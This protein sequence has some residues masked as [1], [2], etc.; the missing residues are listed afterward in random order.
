M[1][2]FLAWHYAR[3][4]K[5]AAIGVG[6]G[7]SPGGKQFWRYLS[8]PFQSQMITRCPNRTKQSCNRTEL[9]SELLDPFYLATVEA[10]E[11]AV[12]NAIV[13]GEDAETVKPV[14]HVCRA[15]DTKALADLFND[16]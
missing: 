7:G 6:R 8:G 14:G 2:L 1:R 4:A 3:Q 9:N 16:K 15:I 12:V 5:R 13:A 10:V 11:E